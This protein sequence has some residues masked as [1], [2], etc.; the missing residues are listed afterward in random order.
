MANIIQGEVRLEE[1]WGSDE[2][3]AAR[4]RASTT[5]E[6]K[7]PE[8]DA[9]LVRYLMNS[10]HTSPF[11]F[12]GMIFYVVCPIVVARQIMRHRTGSYSELSRRYVSDKLEFILP[13][14]AR[15]QGKTNRQ[16]S[17]EEM[18][19]VEQ[20]FATEVIQKQYEDAEAAYNSLIASGVSRE[21]AR[22]VL[23]VGVATRFFIT[24]NLHNLLKM[25][26]LRLAHDAQAETRWYAEEMAKHVAEKF[27]ITWEAFKNF[28]KV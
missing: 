23:P 25:L 13:G 27:P 11:E 3:I 4:A 28:Y 1:F 17:F 8:S 21:Q 2:K 15:Y 22:Y 26:R 7:G 10:E 20:Q 9:R 14:P 18:L 19:P 12:A 5:A 24:M 6:S 16:M